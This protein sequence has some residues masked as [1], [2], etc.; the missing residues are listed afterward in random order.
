L[1]ASL[2]AS[3]AF[4]D[5][6]GLGEGPVWCPG[7]GAAS[8][9]LWWTDVHGRRLLRGDL[10]SGCVKVHQL[11]GSI[12]SFAPRCGGSFLAAR[13]G[14]LVTFRAG[15][16]IC[17][18]DAGTLPGRPETSGQINDGKCDPLG[19][20]WVGS[21]SSPVEARA[22]AVWRV[23]PDLHVTTVLSGA[24]ISNGM[25]WSPAGDTF[26]YID[27][28][29]EAVDAFP[30]DLGTGELG[31][32]RRLVDVP[33][34]HGLPDG[35]A[36]DANGGIWVAMF[37]AGRVHR[38]TPDGGLDTVVELPV[39]CPASVAFGGPGL[40][41]LF[42]TTGRVPDLPVTARFGVPIPDSEPLAGCVFACSPG[43]G[44]VSVAGFA[45]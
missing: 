10:G 16:D 12:S 30:F 4:E 6:G 44:G 18:T 32:R 25:G 36:V 15:P 19:R 21:I 17:F 2:P 9:F 11:P 40:S 34:A 33:L 22:G 14:R 23:D 7:A 28:Q 41:T 37:F 24:G 39:R 45:G 3:V 8:G 42:I 13:R 20:F 29:D 35:L 26:Y 5:G 27:S 38:Y 31:E 43:I 1:T